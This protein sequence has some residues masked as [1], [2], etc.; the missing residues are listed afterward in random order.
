[1]QITA[2]ILHRKFNRGQI[3][4]NDSDDG[5][6]V[7]ENDVLYSGRFILLTIQDEDVMAAIALSDKHS[8][9]STDA[10]ILAADH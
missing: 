6:Q 3:S 9:N 4:Q 7:I 2:A 10:A 5:R 8:I 1:M